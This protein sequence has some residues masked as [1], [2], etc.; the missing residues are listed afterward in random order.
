MELT[1]CTET[2]EK[3]EELNDHLFIHDVSKLLCSICEE[4]TFRTEEAARAHRKMHLTLG[5]ER[6][7]Q[8]KNGITC[9]VCGHKAYNLRRFQFHMSSKHRE[10]SFSC[11]QVSPMIRQ[12]LNG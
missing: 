7:D 12:T 11:D 9:T 3:K 2:F 1:R 10:K 8:M 5:I 6:K 4:K